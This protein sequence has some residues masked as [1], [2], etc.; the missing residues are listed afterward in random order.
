MEYVTVT[1]TL[2]VGSAYSKTRIIDDDSG[3]DVI[4]IEKTHRGTMMGIGVCKREAIARLLD[5]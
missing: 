4:L 1:C 2:V 5:W 3:P